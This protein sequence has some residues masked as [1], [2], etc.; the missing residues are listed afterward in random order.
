MITPVKRPR[1]ALPV[2]AARLAKE[3]L[4]SLLKPSATPGASP[5]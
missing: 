2:E 5:D 3:I 4:I 1:T